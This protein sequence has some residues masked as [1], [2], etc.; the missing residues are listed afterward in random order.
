TA[1]A[2]APPRLVAE[3]IE[4][5]GLGSEFAVHI[6]RSSSPNVDPALVDGAFFSM[7]EQLDI[8][9]KRLRE[10]RRRGRSHLVQTTGGAANGGGAYDEL[11]PAG[12]KA[13]AG[14][15]MA[16]W[17]SECLGREMSIRARSA[18]R[19]RSCATRPA[20]AGAT[21]LRGHACNRARPCS[22][23]PVFESFL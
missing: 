11:H 23:T 1:F 19:W 17:A 2:D 13:L 16:A 4:S 5:L 20:R 18:G 14:R 12:V 3:L 10:V 22:T 7:A 21:C 6:L 15:D 9:P 8:G